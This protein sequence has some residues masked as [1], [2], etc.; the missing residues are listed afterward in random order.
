MGIRGIFQYALFDCTKRNII[1]LQ[2]L[3]KRLDRHR[4]QDLCIDTK[5]QDVQQNNI[6]VVVLSA[7]GDR[8]TSNSCS[9]VT[10]ARWVNGIGHCPLS[11]RCNAIIII[12]ILLSYD[13]VRGRERVE[14]WP[15]TYHG[16][17]SVVRT[18]Y[19][20][21]FAQ[22][23]NRYASAVASVLLYTLLTIFSSS[24]AAACLTWRISVHVKP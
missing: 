19:C 21:R 6:L 11:V 10:S 18:R 13:C 16:K 12:T 17:D 9:A 20:F 14:S 8:T 23:L 2:I 3:K 24:T 4:K 1:L 7:F 15:V 5:R 22:Y